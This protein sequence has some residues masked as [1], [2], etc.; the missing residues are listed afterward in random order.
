MG[1]EFEKEFDDKVYDDDFYEDNF[2]DDPAEDDYDD[3]DEDEKDGKDDKLIKDD[4]YKDGEAAEEE[5]DIEGPREQKVEVSY[6]CEDCDYRWEDIIIKKQ[7]DIDED[8]ESIDVICPMC[9]STNIS[10]I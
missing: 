9:G 2:D 5:D 6:A 1:N 3:E 10:L 4:D 8:E 7:N